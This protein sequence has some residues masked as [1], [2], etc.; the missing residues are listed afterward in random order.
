MQE[1]QEI[2]VWSLGQED[3]LEEGM[4]TH[5]NILAW[6]ISWTEE[7][8]GLQPI[9]SQ[10]VGHDWVTELN[11]TELNTHCWRKKWQPTP[12]FL[13]GESH[14]QRNLA[15]YS[16]QGRKE[17]DTTKRL[18]FHF[19]FKAIQKTQADSWRVEPHKKSWGAKCYKPSK[20]KS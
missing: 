16:P 1:T 17:W 13:P 3:L 15:G 10:R 19:H 20:D 12:L 11:W 7:P 5:S 6:R 8:G 4:A 2:W 18:H 9:W 14:G